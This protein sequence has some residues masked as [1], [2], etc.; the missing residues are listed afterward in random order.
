MHVPAAA[1]GTDLADISL[2]AMREGGSSMIGNLKRG[3]AFA[4]P[5]LDLSRLRNLAFGGGT[6]NPLGREPEVEKMIAELPADGPGALAELT[7]QVVSI[8]QTDSFGPEQRARVVLAMDVAA[9]DR[10]R[11]I[12][13]DYLAPNRIPAEGREI[14]WAGSRLLQEIAAE[15]ARAYALCLGAQG[16]DNGWVRKNLALLLLRWMI[17]VARRL[18]LAHMLHHPNAELIWEDAHLVYKVARD[19]HLLDTAQQAFPHD[20]VATTIKQEYVRLILME[21][22]GHDTMGARETE[23]AFRLA[24]RVS[25]SARLEPQPLA[26]ALYAVVPQGISRPMQVRRLSSAADALFLDTSQCVAKLQGMLARDPGI[27]P[28]DPDPLFH[29]DFTVRESLQMAQRMMDYWGPNP[30]KRRSQRVALDAPALIRFGL[31][32]TAEAVTALEQ[33]APMRKEAAAL[34]ARM[35]AEVAKQKSQQT[36]AKAIRDVEAQVIDASAAG[37]GV[38]LPRKEAAHVRLGTLLAVFVEPGPDWVV[39]ALRRISAEGDMLRFGIRILGRRA[40]LAWFHARSAA[41]AKVL[42]HEDRGEKEFAEFYQPGILLDVDFAT[43]EV[44]EMLVPHGAVKIG[45]CLEFPF[46]AGVRHVRLTGMREA[47]KGFN[48]VAFDV[49]GVTRYETKEKEEVE[50][51]DPW[52]FAV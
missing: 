47:S 39:G 9:H 28:D 42:E 45:Q 11:Q 12:S 22:S 29:R 23:L 25:A 31:D 13:S 21:I 15:F 20:T 2:L 17:W 46:E 24:G 49:M 35:Q 27:K 6:D 36:R 50:A 43:T 30:P 44:G 5:S 48:R 1:D 7:H 51:A 34:K 14:D 40:R 4:V 18:A 16:S 10:W 19:R 26:E 52:K 32:N 37:L 38:R 33:G 8:N 3:S 41:Q